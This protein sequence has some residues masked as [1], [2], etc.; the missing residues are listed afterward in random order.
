MALKRNFVMIISLVLTL[1]SCGVR[2]SSPTASTDVIQFRQVL[3]LGASLADIEFNGKIYS[4]IDCLN[5]PAVSQPSSA[6]IAC[7][8]D[9]ASIYLLG[10]VLLDG[11]SIK[12]AEAELTSDGYWIVTLGFDDFGKKKFGEIT[13]RVTSLIAPQNQI[14]LVQGNLVISAPSINEEITGGT[15]Q[16]SGNFTQLEA[17][18]LAYSIK[19]RESLPDFFTRRQ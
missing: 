13:A 6:M 3:S 15:A 11:N 16:I 1:T 12:N 5:P 10:P 8:K 4:D 2:D 14:A 19:N 17:E 7:D 9:A 18:G